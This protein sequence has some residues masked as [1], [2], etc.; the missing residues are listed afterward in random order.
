MSKLRQ[1]RHLEGETSKLHPKCVAVSCSEPWG[2][3]LIHQQLELRGINA[4]GY[5][6]PCAADKH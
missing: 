4:A 3:R 5:S 1:E 2:T 6:T